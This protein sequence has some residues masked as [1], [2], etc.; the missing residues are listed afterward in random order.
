[1]VGDSLATGRVRSVAISLEKIAVHVV[2]VPARHEHPHLARRHV[3]LSTPWPEQLAR[4]GAASPGRAVLA[5]L[6][7]FDPDGAGGTLLVAYRDGERLV[8]PGAI[9]ADA[10]AVG[11]T[12]L[13]YG[14]RHDFALG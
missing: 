13:V 8:L 4:M 6:L 5:L 2:I 1:M 3:E 12:G 14:R 9:V 7:F 10:D 11:A